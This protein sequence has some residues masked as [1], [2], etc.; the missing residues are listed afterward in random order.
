MPVRS[1]VVTGA[2]DPVARRITAALAAE[3]DFTL[4]PSAADADA[5]VLLHHEGSDA[6]RS[7]A[8]GEVDDVR[9][10]LA[11]ADGARPDLVVLSSASVYGA[12]PDNPVPL[13]EDAALRPNPGVTDAVGLAEVERLAGAWAAARDGVHVAVLRAAPIVGPGV[14]GWLTRAL[15][16]RPPLRTARADRD[17]QFVHADDVASAVVL[18]V[19]SRLDGAFNVAPRGGVSGEVV[20][21]L[22]PWRPSLT[23][24]AWAGPAAARWAWALHLSAV[25]PA[26]LPLVEEPWIVAGDRLRALGWSPRHSSEEALVAGRPA[27][28]WR[29]MSPGRRQSV[30]LAVSAGVLAAAAAGVAVAVSRARRRRS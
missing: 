24:P 12:W 30:A 26:A 3:P 25:P 1:I 28:R 14:D 18:A 9:R 11:S 23:V 6:R 2:D 16:R 4:V 21:D 15:S 10:L 27:G 19:R 29:E 22:G 5:I 8:R 7:S 17:R 13:T 20:R